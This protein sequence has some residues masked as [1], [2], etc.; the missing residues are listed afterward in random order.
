M[1]LGKKYLNLV[2]IDSVANVCSYLCL[3]FIQ[4]RRVLHK[5]LHSTL[6]LGWVAKDKQWASICCSELAEVEGPMWMGWERDHQFHS[7][8]DLSSPETFHRLVPI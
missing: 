7:Y 8:L 4:R 1:K 5:T 6:A 3:K 2:R